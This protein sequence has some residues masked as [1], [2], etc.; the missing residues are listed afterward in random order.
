MS[1]SYILIVKIG[2]NEGNDIGDEGA[3][4]IAEALTSNETLEYLDIRCK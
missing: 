3:N 4:T 1:D 2:M